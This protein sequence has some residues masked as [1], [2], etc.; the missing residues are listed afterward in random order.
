EQNILIDADEV[1]YQAGATVAR[2]NVTVRYREITITADE[3]E[4]DEDGVWGT[5]RGNVTIRTEEIESTA[6][7]IRINFETEQWE[8]VEARST[9]E[10]E[11]FE[12]GVVEPIYVRAESITG[13]EGDEVITARRGLA[14]SCDLERPHYGLH[15]EAIRLIGED[16]VILERPELRILGSRILRYPWDLVLSQRSRNNR[17]FPEFGQN[18]VEGYYAKLAYLYLTNSEVNSYVRLH[19]SERRGIGL[20]ADHYYRLGSHYGEASIFFQ[21]DEEAISGRARNTWEISRQLTSDLNLS[22]QRNSG[23]AGATQSLAGNLTFRRRGDTSNTTLGFDRSQTESTYSSS[24]RFTT[25][26]SHRQR[27]PGDA[28]WDLRAVL[29]RSEFGADREPRETLETDLQFQDRGEWYDWA[30]GAERRWDFEGD[31]AGGFGLDR[32]P[33]I[34]FN[35]DSRRLGNWQLLGKVPMRASVRAGHFVQYPDE[36]EV[37]TASLETNLGGGRTGLGESFTLTTTGTF[38]QA[39]YSDGS[40]RYRVG[41]SMNLDGE[42]GSKWYSRLSHRFATVDGYSPLRRGYAGKYNDLTFQ[43]VRQEPDRSRFELTGGY[44]FQDERWRELRLRGWANASER[45]R[46]ELVAGYSLDRAMWRPL[47]VRWTH[48]VPWDLYLALSSR[49]DL[50]DEKLTDADL[51]FDWRIDSR[52]RLEGLTTYSGYREELDEMNL[53]LTRDLHCWQ[54]SVTYNM[55]LD[56]IRVNLGIKAFPFEAR[57]WTLG[58]GGARL[59]SYQ[60]VYY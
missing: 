44:D 39:F 18:N 40:A 49:Y 53:R 48:A 35:T 17:F 50:D 23:Y 41:S 21:P 46:L 26:L 10:P 12:Q 4:I 54:A 55:E 3:A 25:N 34:V 29:R 60:Q 58:R 16:K 36:E 22:L 33:E 13:T 59:G 57:D 45:D 56:E 14:T 6:E 37:S 1:F 31:T 8:V 19:L 9:L 28:S 24:T 27:L 47:Q 51:E 5:F 30:L 38:D 15:S 42:L 11:F 52:W 32:L 2:G 20:G 43:A 7:L